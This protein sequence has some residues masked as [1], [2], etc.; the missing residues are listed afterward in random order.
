MVT[1]NKSDIILSIIS[2]ILM[3]L[4]FPLFDFYPAAWF[5]FVPL[6]IALRGKGTKHAFRLGILSGLAFYLGTIYWVYH[7][8]YHY[9]YLPLY[10]SILIMFLLCLYLS[11][12]TGLFS[13]ILN[14]VSA[15]FKIPAM[16]AAPAIW[17]T[18]EYIRTYAL[19]GFPWALLG[20]SQ[21]KFLPMIQISA[22]TGV[23]GISFLIIAF[24][25][26][27]FDV[28]RR[29]MK[30]DDPTAPNPGIVLSC[31][32]ILVAIM[33]MSLFYGLGSLADENSG[34]TIKV[35]VVQGNI[36]QDKKWNYKFQR[37]V[38]DKYKKLTSEISSNNPDLI[39]WPETAVPFIYGESKI[40]TEEIN[41]FQKSYDNYLLF[42]AMASKE[43][44]RL[45]NSSVLLSPEGSI[46]AMYDKMHLV[47][48]GEYV[49][50]RKFM[51]FIDKLTAVP[52][53]FAVGREPV[54]ME[55]P[56][57]KI[58]NLI[59]YEIIFPGLVR[60]FAANGANLLVTITNDA[61]FGPTS[62]PYQHFSKAVFRAI[63]NR[64]PVARAANTGISGFIDSR[65][66]ILG[67]SDI[68][69]EAAMTQELSIGHEKSIYT[70]YGDIFAYLCIILTILLFAASLYKSRQS[71]TSGSHRL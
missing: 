2:G 4:G 32:I 50:L 31:G 45:A 55:T 3:S 21:Y 56:F 5:A 63:E 70:K 11:L 9:G 30:R 53:D 60:Q 24:N 36:P 14:Y 67:T 22:I 18:M 38:I 46:S 54:V 59:C 7:S 51:P 48:Y 19:T 20:Y 26:A 29:Y 44:S 39:V 71:S 27:I 64:V 35:S 8:M 65:G 49:P 69:V 1:I 57:A 23:Y 61:W 42:G 40:Y 43:N 52:G 41:K 58:G 66:R 6:L 33:G 17:V 12:Y 25:G 10:V 37:D 16:I 34:S 62:A 68:F 28:I 47:P 15:S 13:M